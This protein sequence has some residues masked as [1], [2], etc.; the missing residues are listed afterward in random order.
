MKFNTVSLGWGGGG[1]R[2]LNLTYKVPCF[3]F[4][5][6]FIHIVLVFLEANYLK[7][8]HL[9]LFPE[10]IKKKRKKTFRQ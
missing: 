2:I 7:K 4:L 9:F 8:K 5:S 1:D 3:M 6:Q 10:E